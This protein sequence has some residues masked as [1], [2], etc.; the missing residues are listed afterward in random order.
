MTVVHSVVFTRSGEPLSKLHAAVVP[1]Q[2]CSFFRSFHCCSQEVTITRSEGT[3]LG[4]SVM[5]GS[6]RP[7]HVFHRGDRPGI[8]VTRVSIDIVCDF[9]VW[10][11]C[12]LF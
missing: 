12:L 7:G 1:V 10:E 6:D 2:T 8:I 5:G 4:L 9:N 11:M 3:R